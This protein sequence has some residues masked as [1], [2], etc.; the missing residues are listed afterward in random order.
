MKFLRE[1]RLRLIF[2]RTGLG[3][4]TGKGPGGGILDGRGVETAWESLVYTI[5]DDVSMLDSAIGYIKCHITTPVLPI[6]DIGLFNRP[7]CC[8]A[9][10]CAVCCLMLI[11]PLLRCGHSRAK[12][13]TCMNFI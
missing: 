10:C 12:P 1:G 6:A 7:R 13:T 2:R 4:A 9:V 11:E 3:S 5:L 8:P